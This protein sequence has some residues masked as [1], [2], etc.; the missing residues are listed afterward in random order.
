MTERHHPQPHLVAQ[1]FWLKIN[2]SSE[3]YTSW[4]SLHADIPR[5][6][7]SPASL[8]GETYLECP[9]HTHCGANRL[10][11]LL[12][13]VFLSSILST[14]DTVLSQCPVYNVK[15]TEAI[16]LFIHLFAYFIAFCLL[17]WL[18]ISELN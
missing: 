13:P 5:L 11:P 3:S 18:G 1:I 10:I 8:G 9:F 17:L 2:Y 15:T 7:S 16:Y 14:P 4:P 6:L 12:F